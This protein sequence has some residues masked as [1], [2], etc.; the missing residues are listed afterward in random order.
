[1]FTN[2]EKKNLTKRFWNDLNEKL[3]ISGKMKGR[4]IDWMNYPNKINHLYFRMEAT[5]ELVRFCIDLQF[6]D[7]G[8]RE[9]YFEQFEEFK[10]LLS[11]NMP[12]DLKWLKSYNHP[13]KKTIAR[14]YAELNEVNIFDEK[15]WPSAHQFLQDN[16]L[17][18][19]EFWQDFGEIF[20]N[21]K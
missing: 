19:D 8:V 13:N 4:N 5:T 2:D 6:L 1:M 11:E 10:I 3:S 12:Y 9:V 18:F 20:R 15:T 21:L 14:I 7:A 16:F 17:A